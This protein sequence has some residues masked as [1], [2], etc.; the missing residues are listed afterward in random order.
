MPKIPTSR[1]ARTARFGGLVA[2]QSARWAG[3]QIA[4]RARSDE[5]AEAAE[6]R[7]ALALADELVTQLGQMKGAAMKLGQVL[8]TVDFDMVPEGEREAF[9]E[10]LSALR[11]AA[12]QVPFERMR[13]V[14]LHDLGGTLDEHFRAFSPEPVA[15]ASI[16][17][18]YRATLHDGRD[19]AVKVQYPGVAEAVETDLRNAGMLLPLIR[20]LAPGLD[21]RAIMDELRER[22]S[23]ELDY[24]LEAQHHR[25]VARAFRDHPLMHVPEV[26]TSM[27]TRRVLITEFVEG[28]GFAEVKQLPE[29]ERDRFAEIIFRFFYGLLSRERI[30][31]GDPHPGNYL[32]AGDGRVCFLD[33]GLVRRIDAAYLEGE[34]AL[35]RAVIDGDADAVHRHL[36]ELGYLPDPDAFDPDR[37]LDQLATAGEWY[38]TEGFRRLDPEYVRATMEI[39]SSPR[40]PFFDEMRRQTIPPQ[41]LLL[42][43][44]EGLLFGV[45][46]ELRAGADW[47]RLALEYLGDESPSTE[48]GRA[49][50]AWLAAS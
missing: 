37:V 30:A 24:E 14:L 19:V 12:P 18:V 23:E 44:M 4:N 31:A 27:S 20:R 15:A 36:A 45:L 17:Q 35:A 32:L 13:K 7:R 2:G 21:A 11:D 6:A 48:L 34:R 39:S 1:L 28:R 9:K 10:R 8:S 41:A 38:F 29:A 49:E 5:Q 40:S 26:V 3:T 25:R 50:A 43:R 46:G 16:G 22:I 47:G 42:R 33:F